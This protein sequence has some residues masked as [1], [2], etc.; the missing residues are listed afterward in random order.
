M[1]SLPEADTSKPIFKNKA[2]SEIGR[3]LL[4]TN[5]IESAFHNV[6]LW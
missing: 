3:K 2:P 1:V 6:D 4:K 5:I